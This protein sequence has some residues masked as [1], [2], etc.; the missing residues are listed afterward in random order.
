MTETE[1]LA[2]NINDT[3]DWL[4]TIVHTAIVVFVIL[5]IA[6]SAISM[7]ASIF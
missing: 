2:R 5:V 6:A 7:I 3:A 1:R 4:A